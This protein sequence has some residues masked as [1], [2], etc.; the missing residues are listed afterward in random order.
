VADAGEDD[1]CPHGLDPAWCTFCRNKAA[2]VLP[3]GVRRPP[4]PTAPKPRRIATATAKPA[5]AP[6]SASGAASAPAAPLGPIEALVKLHKVVFHASA[7]GSWPSISE[8][9]LLP[10]EQLLAD[11]RRLG[12]VR[13]EPVGI[14]H[15]SGHNISIREQRPMM[16]ANI[17]SHLDGIGLGEWLGILNQRAFFF[18]R[19][20]DLT[21]F[22]GRYRE[23]GQ[24]VL[25][26]DTARLLAAAQGRVEVATVGSTAPVPWERCPCRRRTTFLP[27]ETFAGDAADIQEVTV[28]GGVE[29]VPELVVRVM[30][31]HP[32]RTTEVL[33]A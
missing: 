14:V 10:T 27:V 9:G 18:A 12:A 24:D 26:F 5:R 3:K 33:V 20:K 22:L 8:L 23:M 16:R 17:E 31:Y 19:Q 7:Y 6:R 2:G 13:L 29:R 30:R 11:D 32:D 28:I 4:A 1:E 15:P 25:V 21:T